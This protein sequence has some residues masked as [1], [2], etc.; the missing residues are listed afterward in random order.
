M[1]LLHQTRVAVGQIDA[2]FT[3][4]RQTQ[5]YWS[6]IFHHTGASLGCK[7]IP[8]LGLPAP[9]DVDLHVGPST[10]RKDDVLNRCLECG[11]QGQ[12]PVSTASETVLY[13]C[14][15]FARVMWPRHGLH[16]LPPRSFFSFFFFSTYCAGGLV[17]VC[18]SRGRVGWCKPEWRFQHPPRILNK[19]RWRW[20]GVSWFNRSVCQNSRQGKLSAVEQSGESLS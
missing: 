4:L 15:I 1:Q 2:Y 14:T 8:S 16:S 11:S 18:W 9:W 20:P 12:T 7:H 19:L 5:N 3:M 17:C 10:G 13:S 6:N